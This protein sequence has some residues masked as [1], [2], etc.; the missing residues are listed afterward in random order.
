VASLHSRYNPQGEAE[1]YLD[2]LSISPATLCFILVEPGLGY[3]I[4]VL[5]RRF[6]A[7]RIIVLRVSPD[8]GEM[9]GAARAAPNTACWDPALGIPAE[10]FLGREFEGI[11]KNS[12]GFGPE[13][14]KIIEWR[15]SLDRYGDS[16]VRLLA[17]AVS[18]LRRFDAERRTV[19]TFGRRWFRNFFKNLRIL[20][21]APLLRDFHKTD[22]PILVTGS[23]PSLE[24]SLPRIKEMAEGRACFIIAASSSAMALLSR[25]IVPD[26]VISTDGG[27]WALLH[28]YELFREHGPRRFSRQGEGRGHRQPGLAAALTASLPSQCGGLP[29]LGIADG[30][31]WQGLVLRGLG[32]PHLALPQ[33][34]TV[35]AAAL[36]LALALGRGQIA[37]AGMDLD[38]RDIRTHARPYGFDRI[39]R[40]GASRFRGEY[41]QSFFRRMAVLEGGSYR[42]YADWFASRLG[43]YGGRLRSLGSNNPLFAGLPRLED[44]CGS[45]APGPDLVWE[46]GR[47]DGSRALEILLNA[48]EDGG[49]RET[50]AG[51]LAPLI[52]PGARDPGPGELRAELESLARPYLRGGN[53]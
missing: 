17:A 31:L 30:S 49:S 23:G 28:L 21:R 5:S 35:T 44:P 33:R 26:L 20:C 10:D 27:G 41:A 36:D 34:G 50:V 40:E 32:I 24:E 38:A 22:A 52:L 25:G 45:P 16:C 51:E 39:W 13:L 7:A 6:P 15:P 42:V 8:G 2:A 53:P 43:A 37:I 1:R 3:M 47:R 12:G 4:P 19:S 18:A 29:I 48:L 9:P 46:H 14:V 11:A